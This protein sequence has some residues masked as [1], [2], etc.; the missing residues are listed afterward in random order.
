MIKKIITPEESLILVITTANQD[1]ETAKALELAREFDSSEK[2]TIRIMT[3]YDKFDSPERARLSLSSLLS[4]SQN[5]SH[6]QLPV[7]LM[8]KAIAQIKK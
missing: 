3:K 1:D 4:P 5:T 6:M 2:R 7:E 8:A